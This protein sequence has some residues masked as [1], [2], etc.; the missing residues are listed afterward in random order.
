MHHREQILLVHFLCK[1]CKNCRHV[2]GFWQIVTAGKYYFATF[3]I[4]RFAKIA[5]GYGIRPYD[6]KFLQIAQKHT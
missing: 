3:L 2:V 6:I 1:L 5:G 4:N